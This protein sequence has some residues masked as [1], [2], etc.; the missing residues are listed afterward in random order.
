MNEPPDRPATGRMPVVFVGH[1]SPMNAIEDNAFSRGFADLATRIPAPKAI[2]AI[3]AHWFVPGTYLTGN[4]EPRTIHDFGGFPRPLYEVQYPAPGSPDLAKQVHALIGKGASDG[5]SD[6]WG[7]DHGTW[8]VLCHMYPEAN[9][10]VVQLSI[11]SRH[12]AQQHIE[13]SR[14]LAPLRDEGV[15]ILASGNIVHNLRD[16]VL[17]MQQGNTE[18]P[19]WASRFDRDVSVALQQRDTKKLAAL[20]P[21][22][23]DGRMAHPSPDHFFPLLF[24]YGASLDNDKVTFTSETFDYGSLSMRN[25]IFG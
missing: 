3:S 2:L 1:G 11:H 25:V 16:A 5:L 8:S 21:D 20:W 10:P 6:T 15:L 19:P 12:S 22:T 7:L 9:I 4:A 24:A 14:T 18:T 17:R 13:L 23:D